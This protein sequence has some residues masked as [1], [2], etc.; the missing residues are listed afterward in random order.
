MRKIGVDSVMLAILISGALLPGQSEAV[1]NVGSSKGL[2]LEEVVVTARK[3][4][5]S[6]QD[7]PIAISAFTGDNMEARGSFTIKKK[8]K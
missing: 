4:E 8:E 5:E 6:L 7:T 2:Y 1:T 3:R